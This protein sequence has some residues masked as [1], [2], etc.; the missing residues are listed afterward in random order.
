MFRVFLDTNVLPRHPSRIDAGFKRLCKLAQ[1]GVVQVFISEVVVQEWRTQLR[2]ELAED[3][4]K[5]NIAVNRLLRHPWV[6]TLPT[7]API[8]DAQ[9]HIDHAL[10]SVDDISS[11]KI[12]ALLNELGARLL[13]VDQKHGFFVIEAY[14]RG[15]PPFKK[16]K[17]REDFPD[18]FIYYCL[19]DLSRT[20][21]SKYYCV[22]A[23]KEMKNTISKVEN[24]E[25]FQSIKDFV[26]SEFIRQEAIKQEN[27]LRWEER[28][29]QIRH[30]ISDIEEEI[31]NLFVNQALHEEGVKYN[32]INHRGIPEDNGDAL[33]TGVYEPYKVTFEWEEIEDYGN[34]TVTVPVIFECEADVEFNVFRG[35]AFT[36]PDSVWVNIEDPDSHYFEAGCNLSIR[37][38]AILS[39]MLDIGDET[40]QET[41]KIASISVDEVENIEILEDENGHIFKERSS[42]QES[43]DELPDEYIEYL[44]NEYN[45]RQNTP[46]SEI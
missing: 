39:I 26:Q 13:P 42:E 37:V 35:E 6:Q 12:S 1:M 33:I 29:E 28:F 7:F 25:V 21:K 30:S 15:L 3:L 2:D 24:I 18:A 38:R 31:R 43:T 9:R 46:D 10:Q 17:N 41:P 5:A 45:R 36:V 14:F 4:D 23:D 40:R 32:E 22:V 20:S 34:G 44:E 16:P 19:L 8:Q 27:E 11:S